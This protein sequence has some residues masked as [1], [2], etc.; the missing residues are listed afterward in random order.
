MASRRR[1]KLILKHVRYNVQNKGDRGIFMRLIATLSD[2]KQAHLLSSYLKA[3]Q[4]DIETEASPNTNWGDPNYGTQNFRIWIRNEEDLDRALAIANEFLINHEDPK[5]HKPAMSSF[6]RS[7]GNLE[8]E[9]K[10]VKKFS[11]AQRRQQTWNREP[12]GPITLYILVICILFFFWSEFT[13][14][15]FS[16]SLETPLPAVPFYD[17][18][19]KKEGLYDYPHAYEI[20]DNLIEK[21]GI[22]NLQNAK[23]LSPE[24][25]SL[26]L[27]YQH[28][29]FWKGFYERV[30]NYIKDSTPIFPIEAP[31]FEK[32][33]AGEWWRLIS[34]AFLHADIFHILFN[35]IWLVILGKQLEQR[36]GSLRYLIF[37]LLSAVITNTAQ[38]LM[39]GANFIG[40]SGVICA[41]ITFVWMRQRHN[42][43]EGYLL[44][45][46]TFNFVLFFIFLILTIQFVSFLAEIT[47]N[48]AVSPP[49]ANTAHF[50]GLLLGILLGKLNYF[51]WKHS[52]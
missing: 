24:G 13:S 15:Y 48:Q 28:T 21:V 30:V 40:F 4:I 6:T 2:E 36:M 17:S 42:P 50:T 1:Q 12:L 49:I 20:I 8:P 38:Y 52:Q 51:A 43:W 27:E 46:S 34:P 9:A 11:R 31:L 35:M 39:S 37:I 19:L 33:R 44:L 32:I 18:A 14:P 45:P 41:M 25:M 22:E 26:L 29:P 5:F 10:N 16:R 7:A 3:Q 23:T 47:Y